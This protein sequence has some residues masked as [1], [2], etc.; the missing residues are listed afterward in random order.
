MLKR[1]AQP[2]N[3]LRHQ[4]GALFGAGG[5]NSYRINIIRYVVPG[6]VVVEFSEILLLIVFP[7]V[8]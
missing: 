5:F 2:I 6:F 3:A 4:T 7:R 1:E 8:R